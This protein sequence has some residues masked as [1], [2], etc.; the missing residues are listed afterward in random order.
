MVIR[1]SCKIGMKGFGF[2]PLKVKTLKC[3]YW[4]VV[5]EDEVEVT[6]GCTIDKVRLSTIIGLNTYLDNQ[7]HVAHN[8]N[9]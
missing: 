6:L 4:K 9:W 8:V 1:E 2:I 5:I 7:V 3:S